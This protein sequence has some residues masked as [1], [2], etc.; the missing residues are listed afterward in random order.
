MSWWIGVGPN[1]LSDIVTQE[2]VPRGS[3]LGP[4]LFFLL[5]EELFSI[6]R[7]NLYGYAD[8]ST[9][10]AVAPSPGERVAVSESM[11]CDMNRVRMWCDLC[12]MN[13]NASKTRTVMVSRSCTMHS[14]STPLAVDGTV[15]R[16]SA[17]HCNIVVMLDAKMTF[18]KHLRSIP[19]LQLIALYHEKVLESI[20]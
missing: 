12:G 7:N 18:E 2:C 16:E 10:V 19:E 4:Q 5:T 1:L 17:D 11:N 15:F 3:V 8:D 9:L 13:W 20:S 6:V 14:Q